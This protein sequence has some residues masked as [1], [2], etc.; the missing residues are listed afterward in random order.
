MC[1]DCVV[2]NE[3]LTIIGGISSFLSLFIAGMMFDWVRKSF[4]VYTL[5]NTGF[6]LEVKPAREAIVNYL[7]VVFSKSTSE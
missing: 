7:E 3:M 4:V 2:M 1:T 5:D 6:V